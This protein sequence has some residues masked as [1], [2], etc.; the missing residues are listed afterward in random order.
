MARRAPNATTECTFPGRS[1]FICKKLVSNCQKRKIA[2]LSGF[3]NLREPT[4]I[5]IVSKTFFLKRK[6]NFY[7]TFHR[8]LLCLKEIK[9]AKDSG[10]FSF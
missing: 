10:N 4:Q 5:S 7:Y 2:S 9:K 6:S 8:L 3:E 1:E